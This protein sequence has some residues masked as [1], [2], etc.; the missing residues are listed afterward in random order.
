VAVGVTML[1]N[2]DPQPCKKA[3]R[4]LEREYRRLLEEPIREASEVR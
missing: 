3:F 2:A 4:R 1:L